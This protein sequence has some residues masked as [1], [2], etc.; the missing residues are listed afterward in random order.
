MPL[1]EKERFYV[2]V[3]TLLSLFLS[4]LDTL[5]MG[6]AMPTIVSELGGLH[7]YSWVFS[8]YLLSRAVALP[9]FGKL[10]DLYPNRTLYTISVLIFIV[11]STLAGI[12]RS[13]VQL[14]LFR[15]VQGIGAGGIFALVYI[16]LADISKP[17]DRGR[18]MS[19]ASLVWGLASVLGPTCG[20]FIVAYF[21]WRWIF[22]INIPLGAV[23]LWGI[24]MFLRETREKRAKVVIDYWGIG[25]M[26]TAILSLLTAFLLAGR[27]YT[28]HS[29]LVV[30]L[31]SAAAVSGLGFYFAERRASDPLIPMGFFRIPAF[32]AG[33]A[34]V[35][36][37]SFSV[38]SLSAFTPLFVQGAMG[39]SPVELGIAMLFLSLGWSAG[40]LVCGRTVKPGREKAFALAGAALMILGCCLMGRFSSETT[41]AACSVA[42]GLVGSG[43]GFVSISTLLIVQNSIGSAH[44]GVAT[45]SHQFTRTLGGT[46][47]VG[48]CGSLMTA[49]F[50][51][52]LDILAKSVRRSG[53]PAAV[54]GQIRQNYENLFKPD[55]QAL[56]TPELRDLLHASL[57][58]SVV[59]VFW[60]ALGAALACLAVG[61]LLPSR[62]GKAPEK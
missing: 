10:S 60:T 53:L 3:A 61:L 54:S 18:M 25:L 1:A 42:L 39:R 48:V 38:F 40:A 7:L 35:L 31:F 8:S 59:Y 34:A 27:D 9:I 46:V 26:T 28:W 6:A 13:M 17:G 5:I 32:S 56:L 62:T 21:S 41:L 22:F 37:S 50:A 33:N 55:V 2:I 23:S 58:Q 15:V 36:M 14:T 49:V 12:S 47:G 11:G 43:M 57:G 29:P 4:A 44:L 20:G 19:Q 24:V 30:G 52:R 51:A 45:S 16:V